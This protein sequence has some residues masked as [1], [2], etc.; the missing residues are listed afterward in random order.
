MIRKFIKA[1]ERAFHWDEFGCRGPMAGSRSVV[2][3]DQ[4]AVASATFLDRSSPTVD[5][6][7]GQATAVLDIIT[8]HPSPYENS[9]EADQ[10][11][12][13][14]RFHRGTLSAATCSATPAPAVKV[15]VVPTDREGGRGDYSPVEKVGVRSWPS[16]PAFVD[17]PED[18]I[19]KSQQ[20]V[21][22]WY[23]DASKNTYHLRRD[24]AAALSS[25]RNTAREALAGL[26]SGKSSHAQ[27][28]GS[29]HPS[30]AE[31]VIGDTECFTV[32]FGGNLRKLSGNPHRYETEF[33][34]VLSIGM[35][36]A[37]EEAPPAPEDRSGGISLRKRIMIA[38]FDPGATEGFKGDRDLTTWQTDAVMK[39]VDEAEADRAEQW[40]LRRDAEG[41]RD[42]AQAA[43]DSL[44][45]ERDALRKALEPF[46]LMSTEGVVSQVT[47]YSTVKTVSDY[48]HSAAR[49]LAATSE[50]SNDA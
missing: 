40:R 31:D 5:L 16:P 7:G 9:S 34:P 26:I 13:M 6:Q 22:A 27:G 20:I 43:A 24:I 36:N 25:E 14:S 35:G 48:F 41:S 28:Y 47:N 10:Q 23:D 49:V 19:T 33:G 18:I 32:V 15:H 1:V 4:P 44:R 37:F 39:V 50:G 12:C 30:P 17:G 2:A 3:V 21:D 42:A 46:A 11:N 29:G 8:K 45:I 38:I